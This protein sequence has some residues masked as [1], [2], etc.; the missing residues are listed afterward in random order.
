M[1]SLPLELVDH[2]LYFTQNKVTELCLVCKYF[3]NNIKQIRILSNE[4]YPGVKDEQHLK[5]LPNLTSLYLFESE[6]TNKGLLNLPNLAGLGLSDG[7][8]I[9][10]EGILSLTKLSSLDLF[11]NASLTDKGISSLTNLSSLSLLNSNITNNGIKTLTN[12]TEL[13]IMDMPKINDEGIKDLV[14][15]KMFDMGF[16]NTIT[17]ISH[18]TNLTSLCV[19][20]LVTNDQISSLVNLTRLDISKLS[21]ISF[22]SIKGLTALTELGVECKEF[23]INDKTRRIL[24]LLFDLKQEDGADIHEVTKLSKYLFK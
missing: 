12:L 11:N 24:N 1:L 17:N 5:E 2:I 9:T 21:P 13:N 14:N 8:L 22:T 23:K 18:L 7:S 10:D 6:I 15:L 4:K 19:C 20:D 3:N 16:D